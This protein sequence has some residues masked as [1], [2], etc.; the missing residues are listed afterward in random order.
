MPAKLRSAS[1]FS[2]FNLVC[3]RFCWVLSLSVLQRSTSQIDR[4]L[5][6]HLLKGWTSEECGAVLEGLRGGQGRE[7][8]AP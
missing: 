3:S 6:L 8:G 5:Q 7:P 1:L 2:C 4:T